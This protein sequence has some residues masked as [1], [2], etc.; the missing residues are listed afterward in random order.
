[1]DNNEITAE[2]ITWYKVAGGVEHHDPHIRIYTADTE[3]LVAM[4]QTA[5]KIIS[6]RKKEPN[7]G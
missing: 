5:A 2:G 4:M 7:N 6:K 1:M 3:L